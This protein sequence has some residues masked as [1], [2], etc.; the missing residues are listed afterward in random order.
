MLSHRA[1]AENALMW[2]NNLDALHESVDQ[3]PTGACGV[4][5]E[6]PNEHSLPFLSPQTTRR[7]KPTP[8]ADAKC[9]LRLRWAGVAGGACGRPASWY[10]AGVVR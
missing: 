9:E 3:H 5:R 4:D 7:P 6:C 1:H 2:T 10:T 8:R